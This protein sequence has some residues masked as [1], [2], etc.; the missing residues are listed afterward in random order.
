MCATQLGQGLATPNPL[1]HERRTGVALAGARHLSDVP[2]Q[3]FL[4]QLRRPFRP[5]GLRSSLPSSLTRDG[6]SLVRPQVSHS[7]RCC[8]GG[9]GGGC[10][11]GCC[12]CCWCWR[13]SRD[14]V[15]CVSNL[16]NA[17]AIANAN[18]NSNGSPA[19]SC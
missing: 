11:C 13:G 4:P 10:G 8:G 17:N 12:W 2:Q 18:A 7:R 15:W 3:H 14:T 5:L 16:A 1:L 9:G 6:L 19:A